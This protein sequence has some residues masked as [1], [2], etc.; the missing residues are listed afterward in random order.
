MRNKTWVEQDD[1]LVRLVLMD[2]AAESDLPDQLRHVDGVI[3]VYDITDQGREATIQG[4][5][6]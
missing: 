5:N 3:I 4:F 6:S 1:K 2:T